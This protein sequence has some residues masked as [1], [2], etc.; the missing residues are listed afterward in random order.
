MT[1]RPTSGW[2]PEA[3][4]DVAD[5]RE[6][7]F[8]VL[9]RASEEARGY[10]RAEA[11]RQKLRA[12]YYVALAVRVLVFAFLGVILLAGALV[13]L[14]VGLIFALAPVV[15]TWLAIL[16]VIG[17]TLLAVL[18]LALA[19]RAKARQLQGAFSSGKPI[20]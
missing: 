19:A 1:E 10:A 6:S 3:D 18:L 20:S 5:E 4:S 7:V 17:G 9:R 2:S 13:A 11:R 8:A 16:L 14:L 15:G 12:S